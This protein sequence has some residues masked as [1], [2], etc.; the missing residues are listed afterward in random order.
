MRRRLVFL[1]LYLSLLSLFCHNLQ[2]TQSLLFNIPHFHCEKNKA[3]LGPSWLEIELA[4]YR[5]TMW[6]L[7]NVG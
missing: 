1:Y 7:N 6:R 2:E 3:N 4:F 5:L